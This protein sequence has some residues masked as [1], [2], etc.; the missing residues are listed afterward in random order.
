MRKSVAP[1]LAACCLIATAASAAPAIPPILTGV[2]SA[3]AINARCNMFVAR[4]TAM[5]T[6]LERS[7]AKPAIATTLTAYDQLNK[8]IGDGNGEAGFY[9]QVSP[10]MFAE[11]SAA[12][13]N[14]TI[15]TVWESGIG[16][17]PVSKKATI[18]RSSSR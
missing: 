12:S 16:G 7:K 10:G 3:A 15:S 9:R 4:S 11:C 6:A 5:R 17:R 13:I 14:A 8:L 1:L 2:P 18:W